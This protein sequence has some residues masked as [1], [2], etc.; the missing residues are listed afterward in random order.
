MSEASLPDNTHNGVLPSPEMS[1]VEGPPPPAWRGPPPPPPGHSTLAR[2][3][4]Q[5]CAK[6][7]V[8]EIQR[9]RRDYSAK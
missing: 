8:C 2:L 4:R 7:K 1:L 5:I 6:G 9:D 3:Y